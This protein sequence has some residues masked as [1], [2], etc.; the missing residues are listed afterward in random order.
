MFSTWVERHTFLIGFFEVICPWKPCLLICADSRKQ[1]KG[2][3]S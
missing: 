1:Q 2:G 3:T